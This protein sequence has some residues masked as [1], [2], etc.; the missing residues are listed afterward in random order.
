MVDILVFS[1]SCLRRTNRLVFEDLSKSF[2]LNIHIVAPQYLFSGKVKI[3]ADDKHKSDLTTLHKHNLKGGNPRN[4]R[5]KLTKEIIS[6]LRPKLV[7]ADFDPASF[8]F[9]KL[10]LLKKRYKFNLVSLTCENQ[11]NNLIKNWNRRGFRGVISAIPKL[12]LTKLTKFSINHLFT[13][14]DLGYNIYKKY[15]IK[16]VTKIPL[17][18]SAEIFKENFSARS[19]IRS[20]FNVENKIVILYVGRI[21]KEKGIHILLESLHK[22]K[23]FENW[24]FLIDEFNEATNSYQDEINKLISDYDLKSRIIFFNASHS[25]VAGFMNAADVIVM[26]SI[27]TNNWIEQYGRVAP[28]ALACGKLVVASKS[29]ALPELIGDAGLLFEEG[30]VESLTKILAKCVSG[31]LNPLDF[32]ENAILQAANFTVKRQSEMIYSDIKDLIT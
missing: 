18:F 20:R 25:E 23:E 32:S 27:S 5:F 8:Q 28:E 12:F 11:S 31:K 14:N 16:R 6:D 30:K 4:Y 22:L 19:Q 21:V 29:G 3:A 26:P 15:G 7:Y 10:C 2:N 24:V 9:L 13:I 1:H 17:G